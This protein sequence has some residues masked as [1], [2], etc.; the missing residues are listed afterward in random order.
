MQLR[1]LSSQRRAWAA[2]R[3]HKPGFSGQRTMGVCDAL[4]IRSATRCAEGGIQG[5]A[6]TLTAAIGSPKREG[7]ST[8][9]Q[10]GAS[11][12]AC[13]ICCGAGAVDVRRGQKQ[14]SQ[15]GHV[16]VTLAQ[17]HASDEERCMAQ[18]GGEGLIQQIVRVWPNGTFRI[19]GCCSAHES[20][21]LA[22][23]RVRGERSSGCRFGPAISFPLLI[24][25]PKKP[26]RDGDVHSEFRRHEF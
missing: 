25:I 7:I 16:W 1:L 6:A 19:Y 14:E 5:C 8:G 3:R 21:G 10:Q 23:G 11:S 24:V 22:S 17:S 26:R 12:P 20:S 9:A 2:A 18:A 15:L 4:G 13:A